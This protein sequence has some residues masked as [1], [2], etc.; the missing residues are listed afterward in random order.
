MK[1]VKLT[2][3]EHTITFT[4]DGYM[5]LPSTR[6]EHKTIIESIDYLKKHFPDHSEEENIDFYLLKMKESIG[7]SSPTYNLVLVHKHFEHFYGVEDTCHLVPLLNILRELTDISCG[8]V[9]MVYHNYNHEKMIIEV[10][11]VDNGDLIEEFIRK[12]RKWQ[13]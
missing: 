10:E 5:M 3:I 13:E 6:V 1:D 12:A 9:R 11:D 8:N 4:C 7:H 2:P